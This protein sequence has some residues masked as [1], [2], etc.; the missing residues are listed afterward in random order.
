MADGTVNPPYGI[1]RLRLAELMAALSLATDLGMGQP[2]EQALRTCL[3]AIELAERMELARDEISE[4]FYVALLRFL[5]CTVD[6]HELAEVFGGDDIAARRASAP[7]VGGSP[8]EFGRELLKIGAGRGPI[9]RVQLFARLPGA[10]Q[11]AGDARRAHCE[12]AEDLARRLDLPAGVQ[13][14]LADENVR[15]DGFG[16]PKGFSRNDIPVSGRIVLVARDVEVLHREGGRERVRTALKARNGRAYDPAVAG[17][18]LQHLNGVMA[19]IDVTSPWEA[20]LQREPEPHPWVPESRL[21]SVLETFADFVDMKSPWTIGHSR[22]VAALAALASHNGK[23]LRRAGLVHDLGRVAVPNGIWDKPGPL[24]DGEWERVR[25]H[26]YYSE[27]ILERS[28]ALKPLARCAGMHHERLDGSGYH[29]GSRRAEISREARLLAAADAYQAMTQPR[30]FRLPLSRSRA[31]G[32]LE[33]EARA[34]RLDADAVSR[35]LTAAGHRPH[36]TAG[37]PSGLSDRE[38][39]VLRLLCRGG[40]K[41]Q[42]AGLL[43]ISPS[44]VD[45]HVRHIYDKIGVATRA[46]AALFAVEHDLLE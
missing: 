13:R 15:W 29:R 46:G 26:P 7:V 17:A 31:A 41:R 27:R 39:E 22:G 40:T 16:A 28:A 20:V 44:T 6:A 35:V 24:T 30:P 42:V 2:L 23:S 38:V 33:A 5:G 1:E 3:I 12:M 21:E 9:R 32:E 45:H 25:L 18:M 4:V 10:L 8:M 43:K 34:G 37:W 14:S 11:R 19:A 36:R